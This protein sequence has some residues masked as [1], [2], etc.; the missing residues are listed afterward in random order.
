MAGSLR[1]IMQLPLLVLAALLGLATSHSVDGKKALGTA[2]S[3]PEGLQLP[4]AA[5]LEIFANGSG[6]CGF[7]QSK[8]LKAAIDFRIKNLGKVAQRILLKRVQGFVDDRRVE[9]QLRYF[10]IEQGSGDREDMA[11]DPVRELERLGSLPAGK[12]ASVRLTAEDFA[13][14]DSLEKL[15]TFEVVLPSESGDLRIQFKGL[16]QV[17]MTLVRWV[18]Y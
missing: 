17:P 10:S 2:T 3:L 9:L 4:E 6:A 5:R 14:T 13:R 18:P 15:D 12:E 11:S 16:R 8:H 1:T 7:G